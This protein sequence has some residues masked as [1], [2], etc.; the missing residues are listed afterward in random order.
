MFANPQA[1][2]AMLSLCCAHRPNYLQH[3]IFPSLGILQHYTKFDVHTI[4]MFK[5]L[6]ALKSFNTTMGLFDSLLRHSSCFFKGA[7]P[8]LKGL[9]CCLQLFWTLGFDH[10]Y[11]NF[12]F[13][14]E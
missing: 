2:F 11:I 1:T 12:L 10:S 8:S 7:K 5:K 14:A 6:L 4:A 13:I 3:I 9:T